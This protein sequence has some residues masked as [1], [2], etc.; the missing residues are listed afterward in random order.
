MCVRYRDFDGKARLVLARASTKSAALAELKKRLAQR[1]LYQPVDTTLTLDSLFGELVDYWLADL[2]LENRIA[3]STWHNYEDAMRELVLPAFQHLTLREIGVARCDALLKQL[4]RLSYARSRRAKT[5]LRL[6]FGLAVR[7][8]VVLRKRSSRCG[9][10]PA[11][12]AVR[13]RTASSG[14]SWKS[15]WAGVHPHMFRRTVATVTNDQASVTLA[16]ELLGQTDPKVTIEHYIR[17]NE[18][19]NPLTAELLDAAFADDGQD[20]RSDLR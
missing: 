18:H 9:S 11:A 6:A 3:A 5:V 20:E 14:R 2:D 1:D 12:P 4:G 19:V 10:T 8:E 16:A 7:H 17:R 13:I 15:C